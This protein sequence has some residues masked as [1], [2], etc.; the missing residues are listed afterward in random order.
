MII[1]SDDRSH[2]EMDDINEFLGS[3]NGLDDDGVEVVQVL[4]AKDHSTILPS[5]KS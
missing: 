3:E 1:I 2:D 5:N 4:R